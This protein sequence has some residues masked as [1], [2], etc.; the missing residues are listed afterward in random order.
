MN[1][2][3]GAIILS[4]AIP[5]LFNSAVSAQSQANTASATS[6]LDLGRIQLANGN[7]DEAIKH[8]NNALILNPNYS[9]AYI[10]RGIAYESKGDLDKALADYDAAIR[11]NPTDAGGYAMRGLVFNTMGDLEKAMADCREAIKLGPRLWLAYNARAQVYYKKADYDNAYTDLVK[12]I[13]LNPKDPLAY[14]IMA[15]WLSTHP[16]AN[17]RDG[18]KAVG[19]ANRACELSGWK[20]MAYIDTLAAAHAENGNFKEAVRWATKVLE[21]NPSDQGFRE[22]LSLYEKQIPYR[23]QIK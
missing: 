21:S 6:L 22:R 8:I 20:N 14:N 23:I 5:F 3:Q 7:F 4:I 16:D 19:Y 1:L 10:G 15:G 2:Q 9:L 11:L 17:M 12:A 18:K 13:E